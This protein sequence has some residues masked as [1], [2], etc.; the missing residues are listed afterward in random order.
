LG[1]FLVSGRGLACANCH[2]INGQHAGE[3][4]DPTTRGPA[5]ARVAGHLRPEHFRRLLRDPGR[6]FP[7]TTMPQAVP[8]TGP[9]PLPG[10]EKLSSA[11]PVEALWDYLGLGEAMP[12]PL[13]AG[14]GTLT[15]TRSS[16]PVVQRGATRVGERVFGRGIALGFADGTL[17]FDADDLR[18]A[19]FW[20]GGF[21]N[22]SLDK[23]FGYSWRAAGQAESLAESA[24]RLVFRQPGEASWKAA[25]LPA[26]TDPNTGSRFDGYA[27]TRSTV[28]IRYRLAVGGKQVA[29]SE[30]LRVGQR[31]GWQGYVCTIRVGG[32][33]PG[34]RAALVLPG[35][36]DRQFQSAASSQE[37]SIVFCPDGP[38]SRVL[39]FE[40][41]P[42]SRW[43]KD[44]DLL[45]LVGD[46]W[47][48]EWWS[49][50]SGDAPPTA[51]QVASLKDP[52]P[53]APLLPPLPTPLARSRSRPAVALKAEPPFSYR[54]EAIAGPPDGWRPSGAAVA[55]DG[56]VYA[57][58]MPDGRVY[59]ARF[60]DFPSPQWQL[61]ASGLNQPLGL[62]ILGQRLF[63]GQRPEI[64]ELIAHD[65]AGPADEYRSV[66]GGPWPL[67]DGY[68][69]YIFG[70]AAAADGSLYAG[71]NCG[72]F[73]PYGGATRR[74]R[75]KGSFL[76]I[77]PAGR[78]EEFARGARVPNGLCQGP[79]GEMMFL[80]N[81]GDWIGV[82]KLAVLRKGRF[83]GHPESEGDVLSPGRQPDGEAACWVP[84]EH[85]RSASGPVLDDTG[86]RFGP[87]S[88]Q[89]FL[90]DVGY[91]A[92]KGIFR[93]A[94]EKVDGEYQG[95]GFRF[96]EDEP[97]G[98][99]HLTFGPDGQM[100]ASCLTS[101][102]VRIRFGGKTPLE[103]HHVAVRPGGK[104]FVLHFTKPLDAGLAVGPGDFH[105]RS[106][107]YRYSREYGS[108]KIDEHDVV[109]TA[110][111][112]SVDRRSVTLT[113]PVEAAPGGNV[114]YL[115][116]GPLRSAD[117][118]TLSHPEAWYTLQ[119]LP[120]QGKQ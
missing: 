28:T 110:A 114:Y 21:L 6:I 7:G 13:P 103:I 98:V 20:T 23:Y 65:P 79:G 52:A 32:L 115:H 84:Y 117:G 40:S 2:P 50:A 75:F 8:A 106:W 1:R 26:E 104:G 72:F 71:L 118:D 42:G 94:L 48:Y 38:R 63:V 76:R 68:H 44:G 19:A 99:Q 56:T 60:A 5:L 86:G 59:R 111:E 47:Q 15:P 66:T 101:G 17:L 30:A 102:L 16:G 43:E 61:H 27:I 29:L 9:L 107:H 77:D 18:P 119:R 116:A 74:G 34:T 91:G 49:F 37:P 85:C 97:L 109:V 100:L 39:R 113:L 96:L 69:E 80:D 67:G 36:K 14:A 4:A 22:N 105:A 62:A 33:P 11:L 82:C 10:F 108:P 89:I 87:F 31:A 93:V 41:L 25:P 120:R 58:D 90:G 24:P 54:L 57:L 78:V 46:A 88:G 51:Q 92:N 70:P 3:V 53:A 81:Q 64:T 83:Y 12:Q 35:N 95:A 112:V 73:W 45:A 55:A